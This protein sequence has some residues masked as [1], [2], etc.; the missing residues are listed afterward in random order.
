[1]RKQRVF[2]EFDRQGDERDHVN[3]ARGTLNAFVITV[4]IGMA[5]W[6]MFF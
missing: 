3:V 4:V 2:L 5:I 1:M 6:L